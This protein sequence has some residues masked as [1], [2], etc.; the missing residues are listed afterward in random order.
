MDKSILT[1]CRRNAELIEEN[2]HLVPSIASRCACDGLDLEDL[3]QEGCVGLVEAAT[4]FKSSRAESFAGYAAPFVENAIRRAVDEQSRQVSF[5]TEILKIFDKMDETAA[6]ILSETGRTPRQLQ[7][8][9][10]LSLPLREIYAL[11]AIP[12]RQLSL[13]A[14]TS[15][16]GS[17]PRD[18]IP[19][20]QTS[21]PDE[22]VST[23]DLAR[24]VRRLLCS[25]KPREERVLR[26]HFGISD[27]HPIT[28]AAIAHEFSISTGRAQQIEEA[29]L[30]KLKEF[31]RALGD[32]F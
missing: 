10:T 14:S 23:L 21:L 18:S 29:A 22:A 19:D 12:R 27:R 6:Q 16:G 11:L 4:L 26:L 31:R 30:F 7:I 17:T 8:A 13:D 1:R 24:I 20:E 9:K 3:I 25:L 2:L 32:I 28:L 15:T 5:P